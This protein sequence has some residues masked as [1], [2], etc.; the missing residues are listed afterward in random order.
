MRATMRID[1]APDA[2]FPPYWPPPA[3]RLDARQ[4]PAVD[5]PKEISS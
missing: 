4:G 1:L 5:S 3:R 2:K